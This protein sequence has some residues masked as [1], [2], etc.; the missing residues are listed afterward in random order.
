MKN[1]KGQSVESA[2]LRCRAEEQLKAKAPD[3]GFPRTDE[4]TQ[5]I[6]HELQVYQIELE[7]QNAELRQARDELET[8]LENF[9]ELYDFA[10]VGYFTLDCDGAIRAANLTGAGLLGIERVRL[11]GRS[12]HQFIADEDRPAF[13]DFLGKALTSQV[14]EACDVA[15]KRTGN[16]P[17]FAHFEAVAFGSGQECRVVLID[18]TERRELEYELCRHRDNLEELVRQRTVELQEKS[19]ELGRSQK[20]LVNIVE[21]LNRNTE[22]LEQAYSSL[23]EVDRLKSMFIASMSHELRTPLN[24]IIGF[25]SILHD[26]WLGSVNTEQKENLAIILNSGKHLLN[27]VNDVIDVS[28]IEAGKIE[29]FSEDFDISE[30]IA[31]AVNLVRKELESKGLRLQI[32]S[33]NQPMH[34]DRRRLLQ[35]ILNLISN[36]IKFT[37][38]GIVTVETKQLEG[39]TMEIS[40]TDTGIGISRDDLGKLFQPFVRLASPIKTMVP[41]TGL[42]LYLSRK[43]AVDILQGD[44]SATS[45]YGKGSRFTLRIPMRLQ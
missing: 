2:E 44:M 26:E 20:A 21:D 10:P 29:V 4:E 19:V 30:L 15:L 33:M 17:H 7:M 36:A 23:K 40:V 28:K 8:A 37:D 34:T 38:K 9:T 12:F 18:I 39:D 6:L 13:T 35:C 45:E 41:G 1:D 42:G 31:D 5:R 32:E 27:L 22:Q 24:S 43:L 3:E 11:L 25:S 14:N 16:S